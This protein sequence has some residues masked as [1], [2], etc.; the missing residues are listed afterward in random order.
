MLQNISIERLEEIN[1]EREHTMSDIN[2]QSWM[3]ELKVG[4]I[5]PKLP[6]RSRE[7]MRLWTDKN[8]KQNT[9]D[10]VI[11]KIK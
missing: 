11:S 5:A 2:F 6:D 3:K 10:Y 4:H 8:G 1:K 9:F 7:V